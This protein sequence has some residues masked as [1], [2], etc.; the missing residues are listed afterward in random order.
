MFPNGPTNGCLI[1]VIFKNVSMIL[2]IRITIL[3]PKREILCP[4]F[5]EIK[6]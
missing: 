2:E 1:F 3:L 4:E 5:L 6:R